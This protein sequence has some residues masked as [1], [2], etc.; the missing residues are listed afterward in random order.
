MTY[1]VP[2]APGVYKHMFS[3]YIADEIVQSA[4]EYVLCVYKVQIINCFQ[5]LQVVMGKWKFS[6]K[7]FK[8]FQSVEN[9]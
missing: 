2:I 5:I 9:F 6:W 7:P 8:S 1:L 4:E 3:V